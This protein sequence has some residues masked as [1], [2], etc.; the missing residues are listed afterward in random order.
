M[1]HGA[2]IDPPNRFER[3]HREADLDQ[4]AEDEEYLSGLDSHPVEYLADESRSI[5]SENDS[6]DIPFRYS[7]NPYRGCQHGWLYCAILR[8]TF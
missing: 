5:I 3:T 8:F 6:P 4:V 1:R 2:Q 7:A